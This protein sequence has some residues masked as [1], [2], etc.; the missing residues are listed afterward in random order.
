[1]KS[2]YMQ[3]SAVKV[4]TDMKDDVKYFVGNDLVRNYLKSLLAD[5]N[6]MDLPNISI[7][8]HKIDVEA[9]I[10]EVDIS[11]EE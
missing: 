1:M 11:V 10:T 9:P 6:F 4:I 5:E 7:M 8:I 3:V 2:H